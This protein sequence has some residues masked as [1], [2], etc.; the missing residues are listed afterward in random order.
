MKKFQGFPQ[1]GQ[2]WQFPTIINGYVSELTGA[3]FKILWYILRHTYGFQKDFDSISLNQFEKGIRNVDTGTGLTKPT[4]IGALRTLKRKGFILVIK[5][6]FS[7]TTKGY[8]N[9]YKPNIN[10]EKGEISLNLYI[11][12]LYNKR[13]FYCDKYL[14]IKNF[15]ID[16]YIPRS[17]KGNSN[18]SNLVASCPKCNMKKGNKTG[19]EFGGKEIKPLPSKLIKPQG[20]KNS[21]HTI[22]NVTINN[23]QYSDNKDLEL[24]PSLEDIENRK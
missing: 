23:K 1:E 14:T 2:Y 9:S 5:P 4:I 22:D 13:C 8:I 21:L 7:Q 12:K 18:I 24:Y 10:G 11:L 20:G 17:R 15:H 3:E 6:S 19:L 16:H